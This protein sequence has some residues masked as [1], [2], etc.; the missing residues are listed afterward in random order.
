MIDPAEFERFMR[1]HQDMVYGVAIRMLGDRAEAEDVA[2]TVFLRA[3]E[4][5]GALRNEPAA[6]GWL[7]R[8]ATNLCLNHL[9]RFR[10]RWRLFSQWRSRAE[11][12]G[13]SPEE[14]MTAPNNPERELL[15]SEQRAALEEALRGL[16]AHQRMP[17]VLFHF[18]EWS[19][20]QIARALGVSLGKVK[21]DIHR[22]RLALR[23]VMGG[24]P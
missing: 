15:R 3:Y 22:G 17:L 14:A 10:P 19:Y 18:Q 20:K 6:G 5:F 21:T 12:G 1:R 11:G 8:V 2:Q 16:P 4:R 24:R 7:R 13:Y 9:T 23:A